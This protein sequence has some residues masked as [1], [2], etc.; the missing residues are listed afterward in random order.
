MSKPAMKMKRNMNGQHL[1]TSLGGTLIRT[2]LL[3]LSLSSVLSHSV[4]AD[5]R[6]DYLKQIKPMLRERCF[7][8]HGA[9]KQEAK[10]RLDTAALAIKGGESGAAIKPGEVT[11]SRRNSRRSR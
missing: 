3:A 2:L 7:A 6:V 4:S 10:L 1:Q 9:L 5:E 11:L 8:C